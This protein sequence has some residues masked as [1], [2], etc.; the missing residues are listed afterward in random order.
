[1]GEVPQVDPALRALLVCPECRGELD[2][3]EGGLGCPACARTYPVVDGVP[4]LV[5]ELARPSSDARQG[6]RPGGR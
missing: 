3:V 6:R 1:M 4:W 5:A 2:E